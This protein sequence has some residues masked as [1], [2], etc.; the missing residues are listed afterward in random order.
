MRNGG[1][2]SGA[3]AVAGVCGWPVRHSRSPRIHNYWLRR[4]GI[5]GVYV[6]FPI[7]P[8]RAVEAFRALPLLGIRGLN[9]TVPNKEHAFRAMDALD[10]SAQRMKAVNTIVVQPDGSL[11]G[12]N[13]DAYGFLESLRE[14]RPGWNAGAGPAVVLGGGGAARAIVCG[15]QEAG[16][17]EVRVVNRTAERAEAIAAEFGAPVRTAGWDERAEALDGAALLVNATSLGMDGKPPLDISLDALDPGAVVYDIVYVP[18]ETPLLAAARARGNP[19]VDGLGML[20]HQARPGFRAWFGTDPEVD[21]GLRAH[22][23][24]DLGT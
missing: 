20:L 18:L 11:H 17:P 12:S 2:F 6:P 7:D 24:D 8:A 3:A 19:A 21:A 4:Y 23:L 22:V 5:D 13:T 14:S 9:V 15:L 1:F 10:A 16:A